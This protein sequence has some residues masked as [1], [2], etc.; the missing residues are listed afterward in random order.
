MPRNRDDDIYLGEEIPRVIRRDQNADEILAR[1]RIN[2]RGERYQSS[3]EESN[4]EFLKIDLTELKKGTPYYSFDI[5]KSDQ[6]F[7]VLFRNIVLSEGKILLSI[8][9]L[10]EKSYCKFHQ[11][12]SRS[13]NNCVRFRDLIQ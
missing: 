4:I 2:Q 10:K 11:T 7:D 8:K 6:I 5:L 1:I 3:S 13:T 9:D 12:I